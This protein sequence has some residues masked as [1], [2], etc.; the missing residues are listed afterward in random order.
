[1]FP[2][3][4]EV[5]QLS[6]I[7]IEVSPEKYSPSLDQEDPKTHLIKK[8][9]EEDIIKFTFSPVSVKSEDDKEK[10][11]SSQFHLFQNEENKDSIDPDPYLQC[12][13]KDKTSDSSETDVS[14]GN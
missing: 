3:P 6:T 4:A 9:Q 7:K 12:N 5:Q 1:M 8:E 14:D 2:F 13:S 11:Q 10:P